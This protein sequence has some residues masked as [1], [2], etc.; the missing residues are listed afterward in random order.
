MG[1]KEQKRDDALSKGLATV[2]VN[3]GK[4]RADKAAA[5]AEAERTP[6]PLAPWLTGDKRGLPMKPPG[7]VG[8]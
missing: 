3:R 5:Q 1:T 8:A 7:K 6:A 4:R 2:L